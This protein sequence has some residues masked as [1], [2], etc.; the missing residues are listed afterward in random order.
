M[1]RSTSSSARAS[2]APRLFLGGRIPIAGGGEASALLVESGRI[3]AIARS[4]K[5]E[6]LRDRAGVRAIVVDLDGGMVLPGF[7]DAH[8]HFCQMG[9]FL[10][11]PDLGESRS[12]GEALA[13]VEDRCREGGGETLFFEGFDESVWPERRRPLREE[14]DRIESK[15]PIILRRVCCHVAIA[16]RAA[17]ERIPAST[18]NVNRQTG[19][20]EEEVV[21]RLESDFFPPSIEENR[22]ALR[23]AQERA[24]S[25]GVTTVHEIDVP[26]TAEAYASLDAEG[27]LGLRIFFYAYS[28]PAEAAAVDRG[29]TGGRFRPAGVKAV[30]DGSLGGRTAA[31]H[32]PYR[33]GDDRGLLLMRSDEVVGLIDEAERLGIPTML[34]A[35][36]D[37]AI[38]TLLDAHET[39]RRRA[40]TGPPDLAHRI[41]H[42]EMMTDAQ[43]ER[44]ATLGLRLSMQP[45]FQARWGGEGGLYDE[46]LGADRAAR[47][48]RTGSWFRRG[49]PVAFGSDGMPFDPF[50]GL[51]GATE[52]PVV[53]ERIAPREAVTLYTATAETFA[54]GGGD[55]GAIAVG[56]RADFNLFDAGLGAAETPTAEHHRMTVVEGEV[57]YERG[58]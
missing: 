31:I 14:I 12:L 30:L 54:P 52:H 49:L 17:L 11:R 22:E 2:A 5:D 51:A 6:A 37:R 57:V 25:L 58:A 50:L 33:G 32:E 24:F 20:L 39:V 13:A 27:D 21:F 18:A 28:S 19:L 9:R 40:G 15:R 1:N 23:R 44:A 48:N 35:I 38:D 53:G 7:Q 16:N 56:K 4:G 47:L 3:T 29:A 42:A 26:G 10:A 36:G 34:H 8:M 41:E 46:R 55:G 43:A 45:N